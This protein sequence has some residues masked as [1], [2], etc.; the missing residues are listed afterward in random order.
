MSGLV[1]F[2]IVYLYTAILWVVVLVVYSMLMEPFDFGVLSTF[3]WKSALLV[4]IVA[5]VVAFV[6]MGGLISLGIW[7]LG[8]LILFRKDL[9]E[10]RVL[11]LLLWALNYVTGLLLQFLLATAEK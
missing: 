11:V 7:I 10:C 3:V 1:Q 4:A 2:G 9:W 6:P 5:A 8:L